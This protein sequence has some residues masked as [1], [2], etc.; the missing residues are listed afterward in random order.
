MSKI[1]KINSSD[2]LLNSAREYAIYVCATRA[3]PRV[4]DGLKNGQ[5]IALWLL[6]NRAEK[7]KTY[8]L[9][10]LM[11]YERLYVHGETSANNA[12]SLLAAPYKNN[13]CLIEGL[14]QFG[15]RVAPDKDGIG[16]PRYTEVRRAKIAEQIL[17]TDIDLVP[18]IDNYDNS[19][20]QPEYFIPI[21]PTVLLNGVSG[22]AV[23]WSTDIFPHSLSDIIDATICAIK[24]KP[25]PQLVPY[26]H[27]YEVTVKSTGKT[28][29]WSVTGKFEKSSNKITITELPPGIS[30]ENF[31]LHLID[32]LQENLISGYTDR[33]TDSINVIVKFPFHVID[34]WNDEKIIQFF[35]LRETI[36]ER[37]NVIGWNGKSITTY[38]DPETLIVEFVAWRLDWYKK[39]YE[40]II[41]DLKN[42]LEYWQ[43]IK[44]L[45]DKKF[46]SKLGSFE[47][48]T[49][50]EE[51]I[52]SIVKSTKYIDKIVSLPTYRWTIE[53]LKEVEEH[54]SKTEQDL[55][56]NIDILSKPEK[57]KEIYIKELNAI[58]KKK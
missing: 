31:R 12:I 50:L 57:I 9:S 28:N 3:I 19:N 49:K 11:G 8:A 47:T 27:N 14:G 7:I 29:Q 4:Q 38:N 48:R 6:R 42:E 40:K 32:L 17:Y 51:F 23:G 46:P 52:L 30:L 2:Y 41:F 34:D 36:S 43:T 55:D 18:L 26:F 56:T 10:G 21:I 37:I 1:T 16:A 20:K 33:S 53:F 58:I 5:R 24:N 13:N 22:V 39:R 15:N 54:I 25:V 45:Y 35:K 44:K